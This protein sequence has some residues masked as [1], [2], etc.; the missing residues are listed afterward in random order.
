[1]DYAV[2]AVRYS[3]Q[4]RFLLP[5]APFMQMDRGIMH[6][7]ATYVYTKRQ[8]DVIWVTM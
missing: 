6:C 2:H 8:E 3:N 4:V 1:M 5:V 7:S